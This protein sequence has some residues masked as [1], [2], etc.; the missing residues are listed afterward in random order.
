MV[1]LIGAFIKFFIFGEPPSQDGNSSGRVQ[2]RNRKNAYPAH[3]RSISLSS[4][5]SPSRLRTKSS[6]SHVLRPAPRITTASILSKTYYDVTA[7]PPESLDW[8]N[9]LIAQTIAQFRRDAQDEEADGAEA[10]LSSLTSLMNAK[11]RKP[12]YV[13]D[14]RVTELTLGEEFPILSN[15]RVVPIHQTEQEGSAA[16]GAGGGTTPDTANE[17]TG[18]RLQA[19][20]DI[21]LSDFITLGIETTIHL[22]YPYPL[23]ATLPVSLAVSIVRFSGTLSISFLPSTSTSQTDSDAPSPHPQTLAFSLLPDYRL[24]LHTTSQIG[25]RSRLQD[26]PKIGQLV[27]AQL[28]AWIA[29]RCVEPKV[30][31]VVLPSLW[32]RK[33]NV[34]MGSASGS[35]SGSGAGVSDGK[36]TATPY[37]QVPQSPLQNPKTRTRT[38]SHSHSPSN[39]TAMS[40]NSSDFDFGP[41]SALA[42]AP[43][44]ATANAT[45]QGHRPA[46]GGGE[47]GEGLRARKTRVEESDADG[48]GDGDGSLDSDVEMDRN[49]DIPDRRMPGTLVI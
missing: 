10:L 37:P 44:P 2:A 20:M 42:P 38:Y 14:I 13:G 33:G 41:P 43:A 4:A 17:H 24:D 23:T 40:S 16:S 30:Q 11:N 25:S 36:A 15:C 46:E 31:Q 3:H 28:R 9:V 26:M 35:G 21:D 7:H 5:S 22:N 29:E 45:G 48:N 27:D 49:R 18:P 1:L 32:P 34:R 19:R 6:K 8:F 39:L 47:G 12:E